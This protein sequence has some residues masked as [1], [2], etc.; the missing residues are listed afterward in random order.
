[1]KYVTIKLKNGKVEKLTATQF[2]RWVCLIEALEF[3]QNRAN[4]LNIDVEKIIKPVAIEHYIEERF[5]SLIHD[6]TV[7]METGL[8]T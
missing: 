7:E 6:V 1:M 5:I 2:A 3:I 4:E 8:L